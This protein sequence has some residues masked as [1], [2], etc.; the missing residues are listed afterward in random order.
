METGQSQNRCPRCHQLLPEINSRPLHE[1]EYV[2]M[3]ISELRENYKEEMKYLPV[4]IMD[5]KYQGQ[6]GIFKSWS[7]TTSY[8]K[9]SDQKLMVSLIRTVEVD[10]SELKRRKRR[11]EH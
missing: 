1:P 2:R 5:G 3:T 6:K 4:T 10:M 8:V 7:G 11:T 9:I